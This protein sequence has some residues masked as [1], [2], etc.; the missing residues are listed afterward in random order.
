MLGLRVLLL[1]I[2]SKE[3]ASSELWMAPATLWPNTG[4]RAALGPRC[5]VT[6][7]AD[8]CDLAG[9]WP[10]KVN[11]IY[12]C[13][14]LQGTF[15]CKWLMEEPVHFPSGLF[16]DC[17]PFH[18]GLWQVV[19]MNQFVQTHKGQL[20]HFPIP[21]QAHLI[22]SLKWAMMWHVYHGN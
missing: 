11:I 17:C 6:I 3:V 18:G 5:Q 16:C 4:T 22:C 2:H 19:S 10:S 20:Q 12:K 8:S 7:F 15:H 13:L 9:K 1:Q 14:L 21:V